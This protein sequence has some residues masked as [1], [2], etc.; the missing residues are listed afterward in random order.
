MTMKPIAGRLAIIA[1]LTLPS[2]RI[3]ATHQS[4][5]TALTVHE[6]GTFTA[7]ADATGRAMEWLP[8]TGSSD[9]PAF[10]EHLAI[11]DFKG[12]LR[13]KIRMETPI[14]YFYSA[15]ETTVTVQATFT[16]GLITEWYPHASVPE[17]DPRRDW[18]LEQKHT[19]G[20]ITWNNVAIEPGAAP[21]FPQ[22]SASDDGYYA[23]RAT[24]A[25]PISTVTSSGPQRERFLFYRGV[26]DVLPP[27]AAT[28]TPDNSVQ[29][30]NY[31]C[32]PIPAAIV[33]ER[34][35]SKLGYRVLG[36]L[37]V[38]ATLAPP[39]LDGSLDS[40]YSTLEGLLISQGLFP[41]E[42]QAMLE[43]WRTSWFEDGSRILYLVPRRFVDSVLPLR[44][45]PS[46][47]QLA[48]VF[49]GR[50]ELITPATQQA[51]E[52]AFA[53]DDRSTLSHY[54]RFLDPI[55][56]TMCNSAPDEL[57]RARLKSY[58]LRAYAEYYSKTRSR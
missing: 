42:A 55:L 47:A 11:T 38:E 27:L 1:L 28:L 13:G 44:I 29:L 24:S 30:Q 37:A 51:V 50:L 12:G 10:V 54:G 22:D 52:A 48:R 46:P 33:F 39:S 18:D 4:S 35:G 14:L 31:F 45:R 58:L 23:A 41:D 6:W 15:H 25:D 3:V 57:T 20:A 56:T 40:L 49:V 53:S 21:N 5:A 19:Q 34:R 16:K 8:L 36:P 26:S 2:A 9:L 43:T 7:I 17:P 32:D